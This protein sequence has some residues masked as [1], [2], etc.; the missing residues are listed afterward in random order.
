MKDFPHSITAAASQLIPQTEVDHP[1]SAVVNVACW[2]E[3]A[4]PGR[5]LSGHYQG[6]SG[7]GA[8]SPFRERMTQNRR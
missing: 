2:H 1:K 6:E 8:D 4:D 5:L 3:A 7:R